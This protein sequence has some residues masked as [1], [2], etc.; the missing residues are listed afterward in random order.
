M[1]NGLPRMLSRTFQFRFIEEAVKRK[2]LSREMLEIKECFIC[3]S[4]QSLSGV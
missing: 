2:K 1:W 4:F 3:G